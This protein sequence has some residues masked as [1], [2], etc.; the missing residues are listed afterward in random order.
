MKGVRIYE[1]MAEAT[2]ADERTRAIAAL[3]E[4]ALT[5]YLKR[6]W[7]EAAESCR[8]ILELNHGD[9]PARILMERCRLMRENPPPGDWSGVHRIESK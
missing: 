5:L 3:A 8:K 6:S 9:E 4:T 1:L 7:D 2:G